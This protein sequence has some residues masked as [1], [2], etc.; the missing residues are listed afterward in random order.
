MTP[1]EALVLLDSLLPGQKLKDIQELVFR[2]SWQG[3]TYSKIAEHAGYD[4]GHIRDVGSKLWQQ[5][6]QV[7]G[8]QVTKNNVQAALR[9]R[10][11][12]SAVQLTAPTLAADPAL[13][14]SRRK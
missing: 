1:E 14:S 4:I 13:P 10:Q 6:S 11:M 9:R 8:E 12:Q 2:Y 7:F 3:W 5:L